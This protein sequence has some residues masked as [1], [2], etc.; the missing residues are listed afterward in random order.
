MFFFIDFKKKILS[1]NY[2][3]SLRN[4]YGEYKF[5]RINILKNYVFLI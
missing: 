2:Y 3:L 5:I 4:Y 1:D